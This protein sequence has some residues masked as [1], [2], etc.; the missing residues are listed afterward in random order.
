MSREYLRPRARFCFAP[1]RV[2]VESCAGAV[3]WSG[4]AGLSRSPSAGPVL[5]WPGWLMG[6]KGGVYIQLSGDYTARIKPLRR[7]WRAVPASCLAEFGAPV[8]N[9]RFNPPGNSSPA[10]PLAPVRSWPWCWCWPSPAL[11]QRCRPSARAISAVLPVR[12]SGWLRSP[13]G[14]VL[15]PCRSS[16]RAGPA[17]FGSV[18]RSRSGSCA[19]LAS[20]L[21]RSSGPVA[22]PVRRGHFRKQPRFFRPLHRA[23]NFQR[24][25]RRGILCARS[26]S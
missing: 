7:G 21:A 22:G 17:R 2:C 13:S 8:F 9:R 12:S 6:G 23:E 16:R 5:A 15:F 18:R 24:F 20:G 14:A 3:L 25:F 10:S 19:V 26:K 1:V 4:V 11:V